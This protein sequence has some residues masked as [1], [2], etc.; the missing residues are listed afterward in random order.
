MMMML[1]GL[2]S[3]GCDFLADLYRLIGVAVG[4]NVCGDTHCVDEQFLGV[5][6][7]RERLLGHAIYF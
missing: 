4:V 7:G 2:L 3:I 6:V 1:S 5:C